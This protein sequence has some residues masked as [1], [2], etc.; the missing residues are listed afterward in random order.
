MELVLNSNQSDLVLSCMLFYAPVQ[1]LAYRLVPLWR[2]RQL[3][4]QNIGPVSSWTQLQCEEKKRKAGSLASHQYIYMHTGIYIFDH[5][6]HL[7]QHKPAARLTEWKIYGVSLKWLETTSSF[8]ILLSLFMT[9]IGNSS[10]AF[11]QFV[12]VL[13][14]YLFLESFHSGLS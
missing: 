9:L 7:Y 8:R 14:I 5:F 13:H 2:H 3:Q 11:L 1:L 10:G 4:R 6:V 12:L